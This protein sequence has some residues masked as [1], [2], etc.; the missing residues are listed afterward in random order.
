MIDPALLLSEVLQDYI[1]ID[2][3]DFVFR[4]ANGHIQWQRCWVDK[5]RIL[6]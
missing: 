1:V 3:V 6:C 2:E 4:Y 5:V